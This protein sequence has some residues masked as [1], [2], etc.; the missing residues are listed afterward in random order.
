MAEVTILNAE[1]IRL[2]P[3]YGATVAETYKT[4]MGDE[5]KNYYTVW[6]KDELA[7]GDLVNV[8]GLLGVKLDSYEADGETKH[9]AV[10][11]VNNPT[12][13]KVDVTF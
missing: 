10:A 3:G 7:V 11:N 6:T 4:R 9:K 1:V 12:I 8:K 5:A 2:I 13:Q